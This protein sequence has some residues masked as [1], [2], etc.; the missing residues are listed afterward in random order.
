[1]IVL[2]YNI[3]GLGSIIKQRDIIR[4]QKVDMCFIQETKM[5]EFKEEVCRSWWGHNSTETA[6]RNSEGRSGG[7][8]CAWNKEKFVA[9][10]SWDFPGAV[11][12]NGW[13]Q[14]G[15]LPCCFVNIYAPIDGNEKLLLWDKLNMIVNQ[16][17]DIC[18]CILGDFNAVR[19]QEE[20]VGSSDRYGIVEARN[21]DSFIRDNGLIDIR[22]QGRK[23]TWYQPTGGRKSK[24]D[25]FLVNDRW[26]NAWPSSI[27]RG[28]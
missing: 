25:R 20:R 24:L 27:G 7:I 10:S 28:L 18:L 3:R 9:S 26:I 22:I 8:L 4:N 11:V 15:N 19:N 23:F 6:V 1:M 5:I 14:S 21:F 2:S 17:V 12:L 13:W 16:N